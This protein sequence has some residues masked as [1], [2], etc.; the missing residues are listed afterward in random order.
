MK[1]S[2][3]VFHLCRIFLDETEFGYLGTS[4]F[5][6]GGIFLPVDCDLFQRLGQ[7]RMKESC[8]NTLHFS[9]TTNI[10]EKQSKVMSGFLSAFV[11][12]NALFRA[13]VV[14]ARTWERWE[15]HISRAK[16]A[17]LL[18]S[19]PWILHGSLIHNRLSAARLIFDR[20]S[21]N[22]EQQEEFSKVLNNMLRKK[23][24]ILGKPTIQI[25]DSSV[26]F[27]P[28]YASCELQLVDLIIG[29]VRTS[30]L[31]K[32]G[33]ETSASRKKLHD[34]FLGYFPQLQTFVNANRRET[35]QKIDVWY[36]KT[37]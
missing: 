9:N 28:L 35:R 7:V 4:H 22:F 8:I 3:S 27:A 13:I 36:K 2:E 25:R 37:N 5:M 16:L 1:I 30:Y 12:S 33:R 15:N 29:L 32:S 21:L 34:E 18:L 11:D 17:A 19:Y 6:V 10:T 14:N 26:L 31:I 24:T 20:Q 23:N